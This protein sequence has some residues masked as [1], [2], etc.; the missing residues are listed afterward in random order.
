MARLDLKGGGAL[1]SEVS[2]H[3]PEGGAYPCLPDS[4]SVLPVK[5]VELDVAWLRSR[6]C[7]A[8][9]MAGA[10]IGPGGR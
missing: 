2:H 9:G 10:A 6:S 8:E 5:P 7:F 3:T 4:D 1:P